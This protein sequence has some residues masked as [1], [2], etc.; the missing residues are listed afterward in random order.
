MLLVSYRVD[1]LGRKPNPPA[2]GAANAAL[3]RFWQ[4]ACARPD[5]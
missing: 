1:G 5:D 4:S 2:A 3:K